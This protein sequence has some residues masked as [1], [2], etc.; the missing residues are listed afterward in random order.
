[1]KQLI[2]LLVLT[3][4]SASAFA[5]K[6]KQPSSKTT[7]KSSISTVYVC[8][9]HPEV[10]GMEGGTCAKCGSQ[11]VVNRTGSKQGVK[12]YTC[13]MHPEVM[14]SKAG[15]CPKCNMALTRVKS[16]TCPMH[17]DV[18]SNEAGTCPKCKMDL[19]EVKSKAKTKKG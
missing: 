2:I 10:T 17:P 18:V 12:E 5:Q 1:M 19:T 4:V 3:V 6:A 8:S 14:S 16:F 15:N 9:M 13:S 11:L 7:T